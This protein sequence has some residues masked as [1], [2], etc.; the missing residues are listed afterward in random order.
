MRGSGSNI[1]S[2]L[3]EKY[4]A[5]VDLDHQNETSLI[6]RLLHLRYGLRNESVSAFADDLIN[7][8][9][10][11]I[12]KSKIQ[13]QSYLRQWRTAY[14][15]G[16]TD[17]TFE[18]FV[19]SKVIVEENLGLD[20]ISLDNIAQFF[21]KP[22]RII[23]NKPRFPIDVYEML[24]VFHLVIRKVEGKILNTLNLIEDDYCCSEDGRSPTAITPTNA[25]FDVSGEDWNDPF[26]NDDEGDDEDGNDLFFDDDEGDDDDW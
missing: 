6:I 1:D 15:Y 2:K 18:Q 7:I 13:R 10:D 4:E 22:R 16:N 26:F 11:E 25:P 8:A 9:Y 3:A 19:R 20:Q 24:K 14:W 17:L 23:K 5:L 12:M 21:D